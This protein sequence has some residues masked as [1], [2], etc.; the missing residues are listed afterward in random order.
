MRSWLRL[1]KDGPKHIVTP[2]ASQKQ[3]VRKTEAPQNAPYIVC[4]AS[5]GNVKSHEG[6][7]AN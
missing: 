5:R 3:A 4:D 6:L 2:N 1:I 7:A